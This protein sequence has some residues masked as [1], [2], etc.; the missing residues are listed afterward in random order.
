MNL[1]KN[2]DLLSLGYNCNFK[3]YFSKHLLIDTETHFFDYIGSSMWAINQLFINDFE[4]VLNPIYYKNINII[5][6]T[7]HNFLSNTKYFLRFMHDLRNLN[8]FAQFKD[9]YNRRIIRLY[10]KLHNNQNL[11]LFRYEESM[12]RKII[13][14]EYSS[15]FEITELNYLKQLYHT[16]KNKFNINNLKIIFFSY[17]EPTFYNKFY[18]II[19]INISSY[20]HIIDKKQQLHNIITDNYNFIQQS[21][22]TCA[23]N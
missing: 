15:Y 10:E 3:Y 8:E 11:I 9:K 21:L 5:E 22:S 12:K 13:H 14:S 20:I 18:N 19:T 4:D 17:N 1:F 16:L 7:Y 23:S 2:Y 6:H